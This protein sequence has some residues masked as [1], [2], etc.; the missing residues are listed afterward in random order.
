MRN[1]L[2]FTILLVTFYSCKRTQIRKDP[3]VNDYVTAETYFKE[4]QSIADDGSDGNMTLFKGMYK[5]DCATVNIDNNGSEYVMVIDFGDVNCLCQDGRERRG[6]IIST[7]NGAYGDSGTVIT[8]TPEDYYVN[9]HQLEGTKTVENLGANLNGNTHFSIEIIGTVTL[10][11]GTV[12]DYESSRIREWIAGKDTP[13]N[14]LDDEYLITGN[15][16]GSNSNGNTYVMEVIEGLH[17]KLNCP[18]IVEGILEITPDGL[19][20]R[21]VDYGTGNCDAQVEVT[22]GNYTYTV[23]E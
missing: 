3:S 4:V 22:V 9:D 23:G 2:L 13:I 17:V 12:L 5:N 11:D 7:W 14:W 6:V 8:H 19:E 16:T 15:A 20:T 18:H 1:F 10:S 21:E